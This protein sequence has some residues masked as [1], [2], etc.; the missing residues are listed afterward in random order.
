[1]Q[2]QDDLLTRRCFSKIS[3]AHFLLFMASGIGVIASLPDVP[4]MLKADI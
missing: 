4:E 2:K 3:A 1:M